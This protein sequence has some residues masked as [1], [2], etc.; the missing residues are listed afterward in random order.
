MMKTMRAV[1]SVLSL[2]C[3]GLVAE[4]SLVAKL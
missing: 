1:T 3:K 2:P 4:V